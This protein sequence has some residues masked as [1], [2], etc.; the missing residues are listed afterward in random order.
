MTAEKRMILNRMDE[1]NECMEMDR[2]MGYGTVPTGAFDNYY[3]EL[4]RLE[5]RLA[6]LRHYESV[7]AMHNDTRGLPVNDESDYSLPF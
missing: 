6:E 4:D 2:A 7:A 3:K 5:R 1:I